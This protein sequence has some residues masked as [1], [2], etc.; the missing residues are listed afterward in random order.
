MNNEQR[1]RKSAMSGKAWVLVVGACVF[2]TAGSRIALSGAPDSSKTTADEIVFEMKYLGLPGA[3][4][5]GDVEPWIGCY[6]AA[7]TAPKARSSFTESLNLPKEKTMYLSLPSIH[8]SDGN[9]EEWIALET[10][11]VK[12]GALYMDL[13]GNGK[14]SPNEKILPSKRMYST[15][16]GPKGAM[17]CYAT[18]DFK[19]KTKEGK[20]FTHRLVLTDEIHEADGEK[21]RHS[22][23]FAPACVWE[24]SGSIA[25][26]AFRLIL[27]DVNFDGQ[28]T[29]FGQ[30][31]CKLMPETD[32]LRYGHFTETLQMMTSGQMVCESLS[33]LI[34]VE[35]QFYSFRLETARDGVQPAR[36]VLKKSEIPLSEFALEFKGTE[37]VKAE[38]SAVSLRRGSEVFFDLSDTKGKERKLPIGSYQVRKGFIRYGS[39]K[40][41]EWQVDFQNGPE[42]AVAAESPCIVKLG[43]PKLTPTV[44]KQRDRYNSEAKPVEVFKKGDDLY[45]SPEVKGLAGETYGCFSQ[46][47]TQKRSIVSRQTPDPQVRILDVKGKEVASA[48]MPYG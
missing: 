42:I 40:T 18:P 24:G 36:V 15:G 12:S 27:L 2:L 17:F 32:Y 22:I 9:K 33:Q 30:D 3:E 28:F 5:D 38:L 14:L 6:R 48:S 45:C 16:A 21:A 31:A 20:E 29:L 23:M 37:E 35:Q 43:Q 34:F 41:D 4:E 47:S 19:A 39:T 7:G 44:V 1:K 25:G 13:D 11:G 8:T 46:S 26:K 10:D